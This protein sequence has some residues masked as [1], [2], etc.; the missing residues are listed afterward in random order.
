[1]SKR[2]VT[3]ADRQTARYTMLTTGRAAELL[4]AEGVGGEERLTGDTV[5]SWIKGG[6]LRARDLRKPGAKRPTYYTTREWIDE[7]LDRR[8]VNNAA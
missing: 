1:M 8:T 2:T 3:E 5:L 7:F 6:H 4:E